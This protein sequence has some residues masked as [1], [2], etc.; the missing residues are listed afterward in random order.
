MEPWP[1]PFILNALEF[2]LF[3]RVVPTPTDYMPKT[4]WPPDV[5]SPAGEELKNP[6]SSRHRVNDD[7]AVASI[8]SQTKNRI[9]ATFWPVNRVVS[10][11][12]AMLNTP[13]TSIIFVIQE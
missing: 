13:L 12:G 8:P 2:H 11:P 10:K 4:L 7:A 1:C 9:A 5:L 6:S 3:H